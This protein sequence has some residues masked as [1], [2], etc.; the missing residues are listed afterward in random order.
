MDVLLVYDSENARQVYRFAMDN[1]DFHEWLGKFEFT[2]M[3]RIVNDEV[4]LY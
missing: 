3:T 4:K 1:S 2:E